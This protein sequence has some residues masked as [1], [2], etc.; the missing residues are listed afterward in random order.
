MKY[1]NILD[2]MDLYMLVI[3][4]VTGLDVDEIRNADPMSVIKA[5]EGLFKYLNQQNKD[6]FPNI[7][8]NGI[9]YTL[10]DIDKITFGQFI[11]IDTFMSKDESYRITN[12]NELASY[13]YTEKGKK[14]GEDNFKLKSKE[15]KTLPLKYI[16]GAIFFLWSLEKGLHELF[17][18]YTGNK[19][20]WEM[21][22]L[23][24]AFRNFGDTISGLIN[25]Q[26]TKSGKLTILL[27]SPLFFVLI[28]FLISTTYIRNKISNLKNK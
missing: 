21:M 5:S 19:L 26:K 14:Y 10:I 15:F 28:T 11:D 2:E 24:V 27:L 22:R 9:E 8:H 1:K 25:S 23:R 13:L 4:E 18:I 12:L 20:I 6:I 7:T 16:E 17:Q 3:S